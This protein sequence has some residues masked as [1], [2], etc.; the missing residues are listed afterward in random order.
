MLMVCYARYMAQAS[1]T[2]A[3]T[4]W[5]D[6][7]IVYQIYPRSFYDSND[8]GIGDIPGV[9]EKLPYLKELGVNAIWLSPFY[10]S[11]MADFGYDVADYCGVDPI[12][13]L[14]ADMDTLIAEAHKLGI[15]IMVDLVPNHSSDEHE[16]FRQSR[17]SRENHYADWYTWRDP[18]GHD[19]HGKPLPP[20]NWLAMF[21]GESAWEWEAARQQFYMHTF[22]VKQPDLNWENPEVREAIKDAMRFWLDKGVDG[23]R[24]DAVPHMAKDPE[25]R[26]EPVNRGYIAG[27]GARY[28]A[29]EHPY[30]HGWPKMYEYLKEMAAVL[31]EEKYLASPRFMVMEAYPESHTRVKEYMTY[32]ERIDPQLAA[33]FNFEAMSLPWEASYWKAFLHEFHKALVA[34]DPLCVASY[35][36]GNHDKSRIVSRFGEN[37]ARSIAVMLLTLPG[38][39]FIYNG[40]EI[41]MKDGRIPLD[42]VQ[43]PSASGGAG[44]DPERTPLQ[45]TGGKN[46]GFTRA[47]QPWLPVTDNYETHNIE[48]ES[49][50]P[51]SF[52]SLYRRLGKLRNSSQA[53]RHGDF[54]IV[55]DTDRHVLGFTRTLGDEAYA[56]FVNFSDKAVV[57]NATG[58][59]IVSSDPRS[60]LARDVATRHLLPYEAVVLKQS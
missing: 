12:F 19:K 37:I 39:A 38:M 22:D 8:D 33:P 58:E 3:I 43:D 49:A 7:A 45:W 54:S 52:L 44:R 16:W 27:Q 21:T 48:T 4:R 6:G 36:F 2:P 47:E 28:D 17:Q 53:M 51:N 18:K 34:H 60:K 56:I 31:R 46:A 41:G 32:Y 24:V 1:K 30:N 10:P 40:E 29:L 20:N 13:G 25:L 9:T 15:R 55:E 11:P 35:A 5:A 42:M 50:D 14:L 26:D 59:V 23:F 57:I